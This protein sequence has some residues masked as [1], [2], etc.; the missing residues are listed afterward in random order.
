MAYAAA[1]QAIRTAAAATGGRVIELQDAIDRVPESERVWVAGG[2]PG[3]RIYEELAR[4][5]EDVVREL[6]PSR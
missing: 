3:A 2:H 1:G 5:V 6:A 4:D